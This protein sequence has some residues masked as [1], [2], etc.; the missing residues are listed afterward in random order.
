MLVGNENHEWLLKRNCA[1]GPREL[2]ICL[3]AVGAVSITIG[4]AFA[5]S[6]AWMVLP[7]SIIEGGALVIAFFVYG[8]HA[9]DY[10]KIVAGGGR[11][12][13]ESAF[14]NRVSR[15]ERE[16][17]WV[18]VD[19]AGQRKELIRLIAGGNRFRSAASSR[20]IAVPSSPGSC[21]ACSHD[22]R[23]G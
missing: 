8:K 1:M 19:Y 18:R 15:V 6:G 21:A 23:A 11:L 20:T 5:L 2:A 7:F 16:V 22:G 9:A 10:E 17:S 12:V 13:V 3:G 14:G 4:L